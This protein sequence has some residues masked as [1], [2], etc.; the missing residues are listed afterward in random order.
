MKKTKTALL[1]KTAWG[2]VLF[3]ALLAAAVIRFWDSP[4]LWE[5]FL[6]E[7]LPYYN[8]A[9]TTCGNLAGELE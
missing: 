4:A 9:K 1:L 2:F 3:A 7:T 5:F 8:N 6:S